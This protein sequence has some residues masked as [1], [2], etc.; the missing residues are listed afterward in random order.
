MKRQTRTT[1]APLAAIAALGG[2]LAVM[3]ACQSSS[4]S[5]TQAPRQPS[6][7]STQSAESGQTIPTAPV[8]VKNYSDR[9]VMSDL[10]ERAIGVIETAARSPSAEVRANAVEASMKMPARAEPLLAAALKDESPAV[11]TV[12]AMAVGR[13]KDRDLVSSVRP[14]VDDPSGYCRAA[15]IYALTMCGDQI[16]PSPLASMLLSDPSTKVRAHAASILGMIGNPTALPLLK[17]AAHDGAPRA[18]QV[19]EKLLQLQIA[20]AMVRLGDYQAINAVYSGLYP[21]RAEE[22]EASALAAQILGELRDRASIDR[23]IYVAEYRNPQGQRYSAEVR[24]AAATALARIGIVRGGFIADEFWASTIPALRSQAAFA[25]GEIGT[26]ESLAHLE[27]M[28]GDTDPRVRVSAA[29]G[30]LNIIDTLGGTR[31]HNVRSR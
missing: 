1:A 27:V 10:R 5:S 24:L 31:T 11:R 12:A 18:T 19:D 23:L 8:V 6:T 22:L 9:V 21:G 14:L 17:Q 30:V 4:K 26:P 29:H 13:L 3:P 2:V 7:E 25:Y 20:E 28:L 15:A 16:D